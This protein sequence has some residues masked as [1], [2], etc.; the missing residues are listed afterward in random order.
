MVSPNTPRKVYERMTVQTH[1]VTEISRIADRRRVDSRAIWSP[2]SWTY[3]THR[4]SMTVAVWICCSRCGVYHTQ[5]RTATGERV[6]GLQDFPRPT[7]RFFVDRKSRCH[8]RANPEHSHR[9]NAGCT[10]H[11]RSI[12][13]PSSYHQSFMKIHGHDAEIEHHRGGAFTYVANSQKTEDVRKSSHNKPG[14]TIVQV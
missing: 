10:F 8:A 2:V 12:A 13:T 14:Q 3:R 1:R 9:E 7:H 11:G 6:P 4:V 5:Q